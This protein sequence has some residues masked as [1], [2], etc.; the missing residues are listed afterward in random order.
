MKRSKYS[1]L[2]EA[3]VYVIG[4]L[5][6]KKITYGQMIVCERNLRTAADAFWEVLHKNDKPKKEK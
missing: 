3:L 4:V 1:E 2:D 5:K 6:L